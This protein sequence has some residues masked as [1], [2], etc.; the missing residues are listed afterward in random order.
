MSKLTRTALAID[1]DLLDRFDA[2]MAG[3][4]YTNRS[5]AVRDLMRSALVQEQW[6]DPD[7]QVVAALS[8]IYDHAAHHMAQ[9][10]TRMQHQDHHVILCSQ[11]VHL[12]HDDCLEVILLRGPAG[13]LRRVSDTIISTRGVKEGHLSL[14]SARV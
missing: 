4:G 1:Q 2:W 8:I 10:L 3:H 9:E 14:L 5:E 7:S 11:H 12:D 13:Q 6:T